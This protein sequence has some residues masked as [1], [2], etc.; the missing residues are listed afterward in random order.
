MYFSQ[1]CIRLVCEKLR[2][3]PYGRYI[4][5]TSL[6]WLSEDIVRFKIEVAVEEKC[7]KMLTPFP[8]DFLHTPRHAVII[9]D[10]IIVGTR[11]LHT[12]ITREALM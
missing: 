5:E 4:V 2:I 3:F 12:Y 10:V 9:D 11:L 6:Y 7:T 8:M 1:K